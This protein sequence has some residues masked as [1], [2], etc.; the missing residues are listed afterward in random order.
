M[1]TPERALSTEVLHAMYSKHVKP[2]HTHT[3]R[4]FGNY[5]IRLQVEGQCEAMIG[6]NGQ[7]E[8]VF[9]G[10]LF[11]FRP[12]DKCQLS[13]TPNKKTNEVLSGNYYFVCRGSWLDRWWSEAE[14]PT[15]A[16]IALGAKL[17][18]LCKEL[19][20][21]M[22]KTS[23]N[24]EEAVDYLLRTLFIMFDR[25]LGQSYGDS[26][27]DAVI[28]QKMK[29]YIENHALERLNVRDVA[30]HVGL[31]ESRASHLFT[32]AVN[33]SIIHYALDIRLN[34]ACDLIKFTDYSLQQVAD[35]SGFNQYSYFHRAFRKKYG[36]SPREFRQ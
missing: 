22:R 18:D 4:P 9:P 32:T 3:N 35:L 16:K 10:D 11:L 25:E 31:S 19:E 36:V 14:R 24:W 8:N 28:A 13:F 21:E 15:K 20:A 1:P 2:F 17:L 27:R 26:N 7:W 12:G 29:R 5:Y 34:H 30:E 6:E 23:K 33:Q